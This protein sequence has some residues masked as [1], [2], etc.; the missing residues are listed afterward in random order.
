MLSPSALLAEGQQAVFFTGAAAANPCVSEGFASSLTSV[1]RI[2][3]TVLFKRR[4]E[5]EKKIEFNGVFKK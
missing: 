4:K 1:Q 3:A 2:T 5:I